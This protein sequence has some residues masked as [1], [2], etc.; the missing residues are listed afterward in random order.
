MH[1]CRSL[2]SVSFRISNSHETPMAPMRPLV[3]GVWVPTLTFYTENDEIDVDTI[4]THTVRLAEAGVVAVVTLGSYGEG[5]LLSPEERSLVN[6]AHRKA[7]D[8]AGFAHVA[9]IAGVTAQSV[10][11]AVALAKDAAAADADAILV[12]PPSYYRAFVNDEMIEDFFTGVADGS[13]LPIIIYNYPGVTAGVDL[14]SDLMIKLSAHPNIIGTKF[15]CGNCGKLARVANA[16][17]AV[18]PLNPDVTVDKGGYLCIAGLADFLVPALSVGG[19][20][21]ISGPGNIVPK[22]LV[23]VYNLFAEGKISQALV[24]QR[25]LSQTDYVLTNLRP[26]GAKIALQKYFGYGGGSRR[27]LKR[28]LD[29]KALGELVSASNIEQMIAFERSL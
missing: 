27:P 10:K 22:T 25:Q 14:T 5:V 3:P 24:V 17:E 19:A 21:V 7:L 29:V 18:G 20:G 1:V 28:R 13:P 9:V 8:E 15:T 26:D 11:A 4:A 6:Q 16:V 23:R 2:C 12:V